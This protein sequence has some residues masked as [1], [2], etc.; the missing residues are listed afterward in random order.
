MHEDFGLVKLD[1]DV[2]A[3]P[4]VKHWG[5]PTGVFAETTSTPTIVYQYGDPYFDSTT[6]LDLRLPEE[7]RPR[8]GLASELS[9][10]WRLRYKGVAGPGD[11]GSP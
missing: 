10:P 3:D 8:V 6:G 4:A 7:A 5:G 1:P 2:E 9:D 11:S